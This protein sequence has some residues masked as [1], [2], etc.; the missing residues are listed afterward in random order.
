MNF[1]NDQHFILLWLIPLLVYVFWQAHKSLQKRM[2]KF[3]APNLLATH[4][5]QRRSNKM[6][7]RY[8]L[9]LLAFV[10]MV[11]ALARPQF[12]FEWAE[13]KTQEQRP[14]HHRRCFAKHAL[15][16]ISLPTAL[17]VL[18]ASLLIC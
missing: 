9:L 8:S 11:L 16:A 1:A 5:Y 4:L 17:S 14:L 6:L 13:V 10:C 3:A 12:D 18:N 7:T 15:L 2:Q